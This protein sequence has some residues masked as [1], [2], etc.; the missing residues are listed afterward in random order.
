MNGKWCEKNKLW[1]GFGYY[2]TTCPK[3]QRKTTK[4]SIRVDD[5]LQMFNLGPH[6]YE[7]G[8]L[9][10]RPRTYMCSY[11][12]LVWRHEYKGNAIESTYPNHPTVNSNRADIWLLWRKNSNSLK[13]KIP[14]QELYSIT[15]KEYPITIT[16]IK[17]STCK[18]SAGITAQQG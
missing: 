10:P 6:E 15:G 2:F 1:S 17:A 4:Y 12:H 9:P 3:G 18:T 13:S 7:A 5:L 14:S 11:L 16:N 8:Q